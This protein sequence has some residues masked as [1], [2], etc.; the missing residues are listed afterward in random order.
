M[1]PTDTLYDTLCMRL[2]RGWLVLVRLVK[3]T[4]DSEMLKKQQ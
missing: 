2:I 4:K 1:Y 3:P